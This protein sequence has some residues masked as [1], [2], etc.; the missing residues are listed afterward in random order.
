MIKKNERERMSNIIYGDIV[1]RIQ[2]LVIRAEKNNLNDAY[3]L[4]FQV[5]LESDI[6]DSLKKCKASDNIKETNR[7]K[8]GTKK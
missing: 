4:A 6:A 7:S 3:F 1:E 5:G 8:N 2:E